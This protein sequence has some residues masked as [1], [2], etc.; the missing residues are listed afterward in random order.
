MINYIY[1]LFRLLCTFRLVYFKIHAKD[2]NDI[3]NQAN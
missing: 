3:I 1:M 2:I